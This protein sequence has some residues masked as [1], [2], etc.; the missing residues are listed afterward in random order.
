MITKSLRYMYI[1]IEINVTSHI[2]MTCLCWKMVSG[3]NV[4]QFNI[5]KECNNYKMKMNDFVLF[6]YRNT[7]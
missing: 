5:L 4:T 7:F 1:M 2:S 6:L 3:E